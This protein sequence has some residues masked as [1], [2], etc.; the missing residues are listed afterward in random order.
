[1]T[2]YLYKF[3]TEVCDHEITKFVIFTSKQHELHQALKSSIDHKY[4][5]EDDMAVDM[6]C[7]SITPITRA[8]MLEIREAVND[9]LFRLELMWQMDDLMGIEPS[10]RDEDYD[11]Y[12]DDN[13]HDND[14]L[15]DS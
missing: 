6:D 15:E 14:L 12:S 11:P 2:Y 10:P 1:M 3:V 13:V 8:T 7:V 9:K 4:T 5:I